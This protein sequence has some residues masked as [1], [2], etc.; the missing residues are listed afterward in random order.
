MTVRV[1]IASVASAIV[2]FVWGFLY[3]GVFN[4]GRQGL[5]AY[6]SSD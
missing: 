1:L 3:W 2:M 5:R 6:S 4:M